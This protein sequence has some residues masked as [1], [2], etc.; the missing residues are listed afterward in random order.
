MAIKIEKIKTVSFDYEISSRRL[1]FTSDHHLPGDRESRKADFDN[2]KAKKFIRFQKEVVG[3]DLHVITGDFFEGW[4]FTLKKILI[5]NKDIIELLL[6][7]NVIFLKGNHDR[8]E[9][10][11]WQKK[12]RIPL[13]T[14][15]TSNRKKIVARHG[16]AADPANKDDAAWFGEFM[17]KVAGAFENVGVPVDEWYDWVMNVEKRTPSKVEDGVFNRQKQIYVNFAK[18]FIEKYDCDCVVLGHTHRASLEEE[19]IEGRKRVL[20]NTG[21]WV[22]GRYGD[23]DDCFIEIAGKNASLYQVV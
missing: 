9:L 16:N 13:Y 7:S 1:I 15:W 5:E 4:Q 12:E 22:T 3:S 8:E 19:V 20:A 21:T 17:T 18:L 23:T 14:E 11:R 2:E 10:D 6:D